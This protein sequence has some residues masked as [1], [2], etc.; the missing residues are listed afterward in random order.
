MIA[1]PAG[2]VGKAHGDTGLGPALERG[3]AGGERDKSFDLSEGENIGTPKR[4]QNGFKRNP[5]LL[6]VRLL[7]AD[8]RWK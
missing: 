1:L 8:T 7:L 6:S 3:S 2:T 5:T 4:S